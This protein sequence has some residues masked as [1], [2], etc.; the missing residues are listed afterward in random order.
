MEYNHDLQS[1][2]FSDQAG[3]GNSC[4]ENSSLLP[5]FVFTVSTESETLCGHVVS[6]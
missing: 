1:T 4:P 2:W 3:F 5:V 6:P